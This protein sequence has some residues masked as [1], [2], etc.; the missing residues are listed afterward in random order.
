M[1]DQ[2]K[3]SREAAKY[4]GLKSD[5]RI[6]QLCID[7]KLHGVKFGRDWFIEVTEL[8]RYMATKNE[9]KKSLVP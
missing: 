5:S 2:F 6:R 1:H 9:S 8:A 3:T 7:G 4:L